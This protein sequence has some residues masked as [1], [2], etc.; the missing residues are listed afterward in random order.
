M[1][2]FKYTA[3]SFLKAGLINFWL[4]LLATVLPSATVIFKVANQAEIHL[5]FIALP[6]AGAA[7]VKR[8]RITNPLFSST[9]T[10]LFRL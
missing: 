10:V 4:T 8:G 9:I 1:D 3:G 5:P 7:L 6:L 2:S